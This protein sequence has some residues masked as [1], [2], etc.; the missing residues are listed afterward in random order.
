MIVQM[1]ILIVTGA[2]IDKV[3]FTYHIRTE[4]KCIVELHTENGIVHLPD[5]VNGFKI[6]PLF[7]HSAY[8]LRSPYSK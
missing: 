6:Q 3:D 4:Q 5:S 7:I 8:E 2:L 1:Y